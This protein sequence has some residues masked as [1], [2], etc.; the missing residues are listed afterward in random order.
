MVCGKPL[1]PG[2]TDVR[3]KENITPD[4][5]QFIESDKMSYVFLVSIN[6]YQF[7]HAMTIGRDVHVKG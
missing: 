3:R 2:L 5:N 6:E 4:R 7:I 1:L